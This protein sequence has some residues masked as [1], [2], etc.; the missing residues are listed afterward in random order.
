[1]LMQAGILGGI[2]S[3]GSY[4]S[5][6]NSDDTLFF[7]GIQCYLTSQKQREAIMKLNAGSEIIIKGQITTVGEVIGYGVDV[8]STEYYTKDIITEEKDYGVAKYGLDKYLMVSVSELYND[9][10]EN[11]LRA[12]N[13]WQ[14]Q[15]VYIT[16]KLNNID[17]DGS[18]ISIIDESDESWGLQSIQCYI[19][20]QD[21]L[22]SIMEMKIGD[23]VVVRGQI[24]E[25]GEL[26][27][28][29]INI[30]DIHK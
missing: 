28:Y 8:H 2:D 4:I 7:E 3:D 20:T 9:L 14:D 29:S 5:I 13:T 10:D 21:Q 25:V 27:G 19:T 15:L 26:L 17:S 16:G 22:D 11:A 1:M 12:E 23:T 18:Y 24:H 30:E 6:Y